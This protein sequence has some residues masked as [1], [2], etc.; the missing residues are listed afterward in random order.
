MKPS[1]DCN[2]DRRRPPFAAVAAACLGGAAALANESIWIRRLSL[3]AGATAPALAW[4]VAVLF[5]GLAAGS[6]LAARVLPRTSS[7]GRYYMACEGFAGAFAIAFPYLINWV[8][9]LGPSAVTSAP[10]LAAGLLVPA[11]AL[12]ASLPFLA[13]AAGTRGDGPA[14]LYLWN[15]LGGAAGVAASGFVMM[16]WVGLR[17]TALCAG[18]CSLSAAALASTLPPG[19]RETASSAI[20]AP[21]PPVA[22]AAGLAFGAGLVSLAGEVVLNRLLYQVLGGTTYAVTATLMMFLLGLV[23]GGWIARRFYRR[24]RS[25]AALGFLLLSAAMATS[26]RILD[27]LSAWLRSIASPDQSMASGMLC[28]AAVAAAVLA[29]PALASGFL[30]PLLLRLAGGG[31]PKGLGIVYAAN[32]AGG[33]VASLGATFL[34][35]SR[36]GTTGTL[37]IAAWISAGCAFVVAMGRGRGAV[38]AFLAVLA[39]ATAFLPGHP[40]SYRLWLYDPLG[41]AGSPGAQPASRARGTEKV[42]FHVEGVSSTASVTERTGPGGARALDFAINGKKEASTDFD[43]MRNQYVLGHLPV[44]LHPRPTRALVVGLGAGVTAG[45]VAVHPGIDVTV[46]ELSAEVPRATA[47]FSDHN[48]QVVGRGNVKIVIE[49]G[50]RFLRSLATGREAFDVVTSDPIHPWVSGAANLYTVEYFNIVRRALAPDGFAAHWLPLYEMAVEDSR[51]ICRS[52][53]RAFPFCALWVTYAG[54]A[55]LVGSNSSWNVNLADFA[56]RAAVPEVRQDLKNVR[57]D[58]PLR[59]LAGFAVGGDALSAWAPAEITDDRQS[60]EFHAARNRFLPHTVGA[61]LAFFADRAWTAAELCRFLN[62]EEKPRGRLQQ[63]F[64]A[65]IASLRAR[66]RYVPGRPVE[67]ESL[68]DAW[69]LEPDGEQLTFLAEQADVIERLARA[70]TS[71]ERFVATALAIRLARRE[72]G[73]E[74]AERLRAALN[75]LEAIAAEPGLD[76]ATARAVA[77]QRAVLLGEFGRFEELIRVLDPYLSDR[78]GATPDPGLLRI[79]A[80]AWKKLDDTTKARDA[81]SRAHELDLRGTGGGD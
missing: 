43:A 11:A 31:G 81:L 40:E 29:L 42:I 70:G 71:R 65:N 66:G 22:G 60:L 58:D 19:G 6:A 10:V 56:R 38:A 34:C 2:D 75:A 17:T 39:F 23:A 45:A 64:H 1:P 35:I 48:H 28:E 50:R 36:V 73:P 80:L 74:R 27:G 18:M 21:A 46:A 7:P 26:F 55:V 25:A 57:L 37:T 9:Q 53:A 3:E 14:V 44:L 78:A 62:C 13:Q 15:T 8:S 72:G 51:A 59:L 69:V 63:L 32:T 47:Q 41:D 79:A 33:I 20:D 4:V 5:A 12:G 52:F 16:E 76:A 67:L 49:D 54:D 61:N 24:A 68:L 30:F 77:R